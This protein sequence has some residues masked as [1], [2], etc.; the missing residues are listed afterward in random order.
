MTNGFYPSLS[1]SPVKMDLDDDEG[2]SR[3]QQSSRNWKINKQTYGTV[4]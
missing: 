1:S 2:H 4:E 3:A